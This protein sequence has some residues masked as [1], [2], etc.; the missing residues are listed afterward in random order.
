MLFTFS[1][2]LPLHMVLKGANPDLLRTSTNQTV[3]MDALTEIVH[4]VKVNS[5][6]CE[7]KFKMA[8]TKVEF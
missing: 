3:L 8:N 7:A 1:V 2:A 4:P 5:R 6:V